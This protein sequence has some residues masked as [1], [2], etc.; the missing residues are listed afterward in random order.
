[1]DQWFKQC[2]SFLIW[3]SWY[4]FGFSK[5][6]GNMLFNLNLNYSVQVILYWTL[7]FYSKENI[8]N[9]NENSIKF[10][11]DSNLHKWL[12]YSLYL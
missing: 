1:M 7:D 8:R 2:P 5:F 6:N 11:N 9:T 12:K 4:A 10:V 3:I